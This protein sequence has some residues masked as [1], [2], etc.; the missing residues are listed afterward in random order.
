MTLANP[1]PR[2]RGFKKRRLICAKCG[3]DFYLHGGQ[4]AGR[5]RYCEICVPIVKAEINREC[6]RKRIMNIQ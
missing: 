6:Y 3:A 4:N 1:K 5:R 2:R